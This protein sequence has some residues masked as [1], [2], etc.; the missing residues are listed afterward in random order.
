MKPSR[1][2]TIAG[3]ALALDVSSAAADGMPNN[4]DLLY[5]A[6]TGNVSFDADGAS[7]GSFAIL[8]AGEFLPPADFSDLDDDVGAVAVLTDNTASQIGWTSAF[9]TGGLGF[10]GP[11]LA[12]LGDIFPTGLDLSGLESLLT[13]HE[14][15]S[16]V[17]GG[18]TD[19]GIFDLILATGPIPGDFDGDGD[20]D[21]TDLDGVPDGWQARFGD[22]LDGTDFLDW[23]RNFG[24][25][26]LSAS[27][28]AAA[29]PEPASWSLCLGL[30]CWAA[31][32]RRGSR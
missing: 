29:V 16:P 17:T 6:A 14:W 23:Q 15:T 26:T 3:I 10:D 1:L 27:A 2:L 13:I 8:S 22:D 30:L 18:S 19:S 24:A 7:I 32:G 25:G 21:G 28:A 5:V 4:P 11:G 9:A 12:D 31:A 20:V